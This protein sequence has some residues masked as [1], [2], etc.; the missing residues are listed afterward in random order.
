M[1]SPDV[2]LPGSW[3]SRGLISL[4]PY[5]QKWCYCKV[6]LDGSYPQALCCIQW[7]WLG[8]QAGVVWYSETLGASSI[9]PRA[10]ER[11][12]NNPHL[13]GLWIYPFLQIKM[14]CY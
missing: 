14:S 13:R 6:F 1:P 10:E 4:Y 7:V 8:E 9:R 2:S 11:H 5:E 12:V 3:W